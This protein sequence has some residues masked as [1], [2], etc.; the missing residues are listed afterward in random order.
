MQRMTVSFTLLLQNLY[1]IMDE[2][3]ISKDWRDHGVGMVVG[4]IGEVLWVD[5]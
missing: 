5:T 3:N 1:I 2:L 4:K